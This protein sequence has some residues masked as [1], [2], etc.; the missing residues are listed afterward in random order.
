LQSLAHLFKPFRFKTNE[1]HTLQDSEIELLYTIVSLLISTKAF[2]MQQSEVNW[3]Q[4]V[5]GPSAASVSRQ[6]DELCVPFRESSL[7]FKLSE[8]HPIPLTEVQEKIEMSHDISILQ[9]LLENLNSSDFADRISDLCALRDQYGKET[10]LDE[11]RSRRRSTNLF[12]Q[13]L[14]R[15]SRSE[16]S[17]RGISSFK[18]RSFLAVLPTFLSAIVK[19][20]ARWLLSNVF[21]R[22][23]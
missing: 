18:R 5:L 16:K 14:S 7:A 22:R 20:T 17:I 23:A 4:F 15:S 2:F 8:S 1:D 21:T 12:L 11:A 19:V 3:L 6:A 10:G 9:Q 13:K